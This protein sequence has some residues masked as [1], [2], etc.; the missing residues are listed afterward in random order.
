MIRRDG[1]L[2]MVPGIALVARDDRDARARVTL[3]PLAAGLFVVVRVGERHPEAP[4]ARRL[5]RAGTDVCRVG[6]GRTLEL[7]HRLDNEILTVRDRGEARRRDR[8][9]RPL[10]LSAVR[11]DKRVL[12]GVVL[13]QGLDRGA[14]VLMA[15]LHRRG[16]ERGFGLAVEL[17]TPL[18]KRRRIVIEQ[19]LLFQ[20]LVDGVA[21]DRERPARLRQELLLEP[22]LVCLE[23]TRRG[24][25]GGPE[26]A[27]RGALKRACCRHHRLRA[28][29]Q[30]GRPRGHGAKS[31]L[32]E[33]GRHERRIEIRLRRFERGRSVRESLGERRDA[34][35]ERRV[36]AQERVV[37]AADDRVGVDGWLPP[38]P[39]E[40]ANGTLAA[41][42]RDDQRAVDTLRRKEL[43]LGEGLEARERLIVEAVARRESV[44]AEVTEA[45]VVSVDPR[46]RCRDGIERVAPVDEV[47]GVLAEARE[48]ERL[49]AVGAELGVA[50]VGPPA[51]A[52]VDRRAGRRRRGGRRRTGRDRCGLV[53]R[54]FV[55]EAPHTLAKLAEDVG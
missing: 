52:A 41:Q 2:E 23:R 28:D 34:L 37:R 20:P 13:A 45:I 55:S 9:T 27:L 24:F 3:E 30:E 25:G 26:R 32:D 17:V 21:S 6:I 22:E 35:G 14:P 49:P 54:R 11:L 42:V 46:D 40:R 38:P 29:A 44:G 1:E 7:G 4:A 18:A 53:V 31:D 48:L 5:E 36:L 33:L 15:D 12:G 8:Q 16:V 10:H 50:G 47:V 19:L 43:V 51:V 39:R